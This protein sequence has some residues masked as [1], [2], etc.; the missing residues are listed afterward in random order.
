MIK[1]FEQFINYQLDEVFKAPNTKTDIEEK[2]INS[3]KALQFC[4]YLRKNYN[5]DGCDIERSSYRK[6]TTY[7]IPILRRSDGDIVH[8]MLHPLRPNSGYFDNIELNIYPG[9]SRHPEEDEE[10][11]NKIKGEL[12]FD[13]H[14]FEAGCV[15][16]ALHFKYKLYSNEEVLK[17]IDVLIDKLDNLVISKK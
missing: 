16:T 9:F 17:I 13:K 14:Q 12:D 4:T 6:Y 10:I 5:F 7:Y 8:L 15:V 11:L 1:N 2:D 3:L